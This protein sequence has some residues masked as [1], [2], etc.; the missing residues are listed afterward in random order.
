MDSPSYARN[1]RKDLFGAGTYA[2]LGGLVKNGLPSGQ[3]HYTD[4][5]SAPAA[6]WQGLDGVFSRL[7]STLGEHE[8]LF[9]HI[10]ETSTIISHHVRDTVTFV[11][12]GAV[13]E[14]VICKFTTS[15]GG[16]GKCYDAIIAFL[17]RSF[18]GGS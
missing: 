2:F 14:E 7:L 16:S 17:S 11:D 18:R 6:W 5:L 8:C 1:D 4:Q 3:E 13:H 12:P 10:L 9:D 15:E